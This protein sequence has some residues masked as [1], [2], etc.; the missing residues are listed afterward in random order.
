MLAMAKGKTRVGGLWTY[1]RDHRPFGG[2]DPPAAFFYSPDRSTK[3]PSIWRV[4]PD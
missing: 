4:M 2:G 3:H 1:V